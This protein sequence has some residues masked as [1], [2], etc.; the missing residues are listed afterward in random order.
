MQERMNSGLGFIGSCADDRAEKPQDKHMSLGSIVNRQS[1]F[2]VGPLYLGM[3][4]S[5]EFVIV[6][7][8]VRRHGREQMLSRYP[9]KL[10]INRS[11]HH[12]CVN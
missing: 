4:G 6:H 5:K 1:A 7:D 9:F 12:S 3:C 11:M 2:E 8:I 10:G